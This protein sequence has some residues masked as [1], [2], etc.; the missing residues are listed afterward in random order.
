[1][2][3]M[4][5]DPQYLEHQAEAAVHHFH[6]PSILSKHKP[7]VSGLEQQPSHHIHYL[8]REYLV[9]YGPDSDIRETKLFYYIEMEVPGTTNQDDILVQWMS[10][11]T[12][13]VEGTA[14]RP[15]VGRESNEGA[16][17]VWENEDAG[18]GSKSSDPP[19]PATT[20]GATNPTTTS[21]KN[22]NVGVPLHKCLDE[23]DDD[24]VI[25]VL[26]AERKIG[27][28]HRSFTL[29]ADVNMKGL[30][31]K[32]EG[33]LLRISLPKRSLVD[34]PKFKIEVE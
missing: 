9:P 23:E 12:L 4:A 6:L 26:L 19:A 27:S 31:A 25:R 16:E 3:V 34:E 21:T 22:G 2:S 14:N 33:G 5:W 11:R 1:M 24:Y 17:P 13:V 32:L 7:S 15:N 30:K 28:W 29:P 18:V 8:P 20:N 10:P